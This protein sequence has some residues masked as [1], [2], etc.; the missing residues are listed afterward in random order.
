[1]SHSHAGG[2]A[3]T[4]RA[5]ALR[6]RQDR[7]R[8]A[9]RPLWYSRAPDDLERGSA[10]CARVHRATDRSSGSDGSL[11]QACVPVDRTGAVS[12]ELQALIGKAAN[13]GCVRTGWIAGPCRAGGLSR[14]STRT[15]YL[16]SRLD[17]KAYRAIVELRTLNAKG[18]ASMIRRF[19]PV[20]KPRTPCRASCPPWEG[21][22]AAIW[23]L[24]W[25]EEGTSDVSEPSS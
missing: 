2:G 6:R 11:I 25:R 23:R 21:L 16:R 7:L 14:S 22:A 8:S 15:P 3:C 17:P 10:A 1:M 4:E 12:A 9:S 18:G 24:P 19:P 5:E 13:C 20:I